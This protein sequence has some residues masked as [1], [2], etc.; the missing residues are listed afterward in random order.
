MHI[1][2]LQAVSGSCEPIDIRNVLVLAI[3]RRNA[4]NALR[5]R[6]GSRA[7]NVIVAVGKL[8]ARKSDSYGIDVGAI[9]CDRDAPRWKSAHG[10]AQTGSEVARF[11]IIGH[12]IQRC[13]RE[14]L[15]GYPVELARSLIASEEKQ[16]VLLD[17]P[18]DAAPI[19]V[20]SQYLLGGRS[21]KP[22]PVIEK[23]VRI[24]CLVPKELKQ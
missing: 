6:A 20:L 2:H 1:L 4:E 13:G 17:R 18:A 10:R 22:V 11:A 5:R 21:W 16:L 8:H 19:L 12:G 23:V 14:P 9:A 24:Q 15:S 7:G 3:F